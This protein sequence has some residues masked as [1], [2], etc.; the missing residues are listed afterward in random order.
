MTALVEWAVF[1]LAVSWAICTNIALRR[2]YKNSERPALP[3][4]ATALVQL[5][6]VVGVV[7][8]GYSPFHLLWLHERLGFGPL[9]V[10]FV[11]GAAIWLFAVGSVPTNWITI[12]AVPL[13]IGLT[14]GIYRCR[15][16]AIYG[17]W[18]RTTCTPGEFA[19]TIRKMAN[20]RQQKARI[21]L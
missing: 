7:A 18:R 21:R 8:A 10:L 14:A 20:R 6:S 12:L 13:A 4:N 9:Y 2:H 3:P 17:C 19:A 16:R 5:T 1:A 11:I 15:C